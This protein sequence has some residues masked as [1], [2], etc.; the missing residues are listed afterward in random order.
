M[1]SVDVIAQ[2][3]VSGLL[4]G[5]VYA[6]IAI[7]F[8]LVFGVLDVVNFAH[9]HQVVVAMFATYVL[10]TAFGIDPY[11]ALIIVVPGMFV[12]GMFIYWVVVS[13]IVE[14]HHFAHIMVTLGLLIFIENLASFTFGGDLR[15]ITTS[16]TTASYQIAGI[17]VPVARAGAAAVS[18]VTVV[19]LSLF[20]RYSSF[21]MAIRAAANNR[22]GAHLV[23]VN[24]RR[25]Y[26]VAFA[27]GTAITGIAGVVLMPFS[28]VSPFEGIEFA[29]KAF[30]IVIIG[31]L[32]SVLGS[33]VAGL[34]IGLTEAFAALFFAA[35]IGNVLVFAIL[36]AVLLFRP[37]G[38][39][40]RG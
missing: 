18:L 28:L 2:V 9:G 37:S 6:L 22:I 26:T 15:G 1:W 32:G 31:G 8:T 40:A 38:L 14:A 17:S 25:V 29:I 21:G 30:V 11:A 39:F 7:G 4:M 16:Y 20:L 13:K 23:G 10:F 12:L 27:L 3:L 24:V 33:L 19:L 5:A 35:S 36:I 34:L